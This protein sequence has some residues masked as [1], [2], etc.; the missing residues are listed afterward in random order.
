MNNKKNK[1]EV[2]NDCVQFSI[3]YKGGK[4]ANDFQSGSLGKGVRP[5]FPEFPTKALQLFPSWA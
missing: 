5:L 2:E 1:V 3:S 4:V